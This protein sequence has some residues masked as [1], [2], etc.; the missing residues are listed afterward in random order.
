MPVKTKKEFERVRS[1]FFFSL[2]IILGIG[3]L[4]LIRPFLYPIFWAV[5]LAILFYPLYEL[6]LKLAKFP[7]IASVLSVISVIAILVV[8]L[9]FIGVLVARESVNIYTEATMTDW[10]GHL[11][12]VTEKLNSTPLGP[13]LEKFSTNSSD[14]AAQVTKTVVDFLIENLAPIT[15]NS[16]SFFAMVFLMLYTLYYFFKD[17]PR[18]LRRVMHLSPLGDRYEQMLYDRFTST[19][20]AT[21]KGT[22]IVGT[23]QGTLAGILFFIVG[24]KGALIWSIIMIA[25][26]IIPALGPFIVWLPMGI[27]LLITGQYW[28]GATV[29]IVGST[30]ISM[31]DNILRPILVGKDTQ[32]HPLVVLFS[33]LGGILLFDISGFVI[34]PVIAALFTA[35][36]SIY[37]S[38][39]STELKQN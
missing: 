17:G 37:D 3:L 36:M 22:F 2:I 30:L 29:L 5:I 39:Y 34:G 11:Y 19:A 7:S 26:S 13:Y 31:I 27:V 25:C 20:R 28:Q 24:V 12:S 10:Q 1:I 16:I 33:T 35:I 21:L 18:M 15:Q 6:M 32:L 8:P 38:H 14:F 4:Y 9:F 23:I